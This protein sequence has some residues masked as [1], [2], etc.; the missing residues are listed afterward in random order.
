MKHYF[1]SR[2]LKVLLIATSVFAASCEK[3][4]LALDQSHQFKLKDDKDAMSLG[5]KLNDPYNLDFITRAFDQM[6]NEGVDFP[7][8][9]LMPTGMYVRLLANTTNELDII[10]GDTNTLWFDFPLDYEIP[11]G[12]TYYHDSS[13][14][15]SATWKYAVVPL[16][17]K[18]P[19]NIYKEVLYYVFIP[20]EHPDYQKYEST[21]D[22]LEEL[23]EFMCNNKKESANEQGA[24]G[25]KCSK[26]APSATI[27]AWDDIVNDYVPL[28]GVKVTAR[29]YTKCR[30]GYTNSDG[31]YTFAA[32]FKKG[33]RVKYG[34]TWE[35]AYWDIRDGKWWQAYYNGD[36]T[37][38]PW[39][40]NI[41]GQKSLMYATIHRAAYKAFYG[42]FGDIQRPYAS[43]SLKIAYHHDNNGSVNGNNICFFNLF[44]LLPNINIW[45]KNTYGN[46]KS[47]D[48]VYGTVIHEMAH[49]SHL[50]HNFMSF[51]ISNKFICESWAR[52]IQWKITNHHYNAD[53]GITTYNHKNGFQD[54]ARS[55]TYNNG[56]PYPYTPVFIDLIDNINQYEQDQNQCKDNISGYSLL[57]IQNTILGRSYNLKILRSRL[58]S[59]LLH[60]ATVEDVDELL[61]NYIDL[62]F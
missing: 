2:S 55:N 21:F 8:S 35:R 43:H 13:L 1:I 10:K 41:S 60:G 59:N 18:F 58:K 40:L 19:N 52:C 30:S 27:R 51:Y 17:Y 39:N 47:T 42:Y 25:S 48:E 16:D 3:G 61:D 53:L 54:W 15:D 34:I 45:G 33:H 6:R 56:Y 50:K 57:E 36:K 9:E 31:K 14:P 37:K 4:N 44:G 12:G 28:E 11:E 5:E 24:T 20:D 7:F 62:G 46:R 22:E 23:S 29:H 49:Q 26:W 32:E 38:T